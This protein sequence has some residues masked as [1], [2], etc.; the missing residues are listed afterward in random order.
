MIGQTVVQKLEMCEMLREGL[1]KA[2][3]YP[4]S[5]DR[6]LDNLEREMDLMEA[7]LEEEETTAKKLE[8]EGEFYAKL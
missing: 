1:A 6:E 4:D 2:A 8:G 5:R 7:K 3:T